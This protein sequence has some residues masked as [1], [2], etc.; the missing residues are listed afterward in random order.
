MSSMYSFII[1]DAAGAAVERFSDVLAFDSQRVVN[2][3]GSLTFSLPANHPAVASIGHLALVSLYRREPAQGLAWTLENCGLALSRGWSYPDNGSTG[4]PIFT[5]TALHPNWLLSTRIVYWKAGTSGRSY[6]SETPAETIAKTLVA[7]NAAALSGAADGRERDGWDTLRPITVQA[8]GAGGP[9]LTWQCAYHNLLAT[10]QRLAALSGAD[11][12]LLPQGGGY[13][14]RWYPDGLGSDRAA[15]VIFSIERGNIA[16]PAYELDRRKEKT[17]A[18]AG[19]RGQG[20]LR[21]TLHACSTAYSP[22][23]D[24]EGFTT[25]YQAETNAGML[26]V[27]GHYLAR[28]AAPARLTFDV[29]QMPSTCYG[30]HYFLGDRVTVRNPF[31]A[32]DYPA[33]VLA[34]RIAFCQP[35]PGRAAA[36]LIQIDLGETGALDAFPETLEELQTADSGEIDGLDAAAFND[37]EAVIF[38]LDAGPFAVV[39]L[40]AGVS[41]GAFRPPPG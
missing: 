10:L 26:A 1:H 12:D 4:A 35:Q 34:A 39:Y 19:G 23:N 5:C 7:A 24:I 30:V 21:R 16:N 29:L 27:A 25:S 31:T 6:F 8:D 37:P 18:V 14:F 9:I 15:Q 22:E 13:E 41:G 20:I 2:G 40:S 38:T 28:C 3:I 17:V 11:F 33:R 32:Q 36:P